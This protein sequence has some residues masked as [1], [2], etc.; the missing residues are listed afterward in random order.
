M[1][2]EERTGL[3][4]ECLP[5]TFFTL[6]GVAHSYFNTFEKTEQL[7]HRNIFGNWDGSFLKK[8]LLMLSFVSRSVNYQHSIRSY[9]Y[10]QFHF[11]ILRTS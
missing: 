11:N 5:E 7:R 6:S 1:V 8:L 4:I 9:V 2:S 10:V 3:E